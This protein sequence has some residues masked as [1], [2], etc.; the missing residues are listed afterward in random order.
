MAEFFIKNLSEIKIDEI[1]SAKSVALG[2]D[3]GE[4]TIGV[5]ISDRRIKIASGVT[6]I[7]RKRTDRDFE[8]LLES[9]KYHKIGVV[10]LGWPLQ[11]NGLA[12]EQC[13]K[14]LEFAV[15]LSKYI[16]ADFV[17]WDERF[18]TKV[19]NNLMIRA[20]LSRKKRKKIVDSSAAAYIL[21]G[22]IDFMNYSAAGDRVFKELE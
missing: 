9:V 18:S 5:A 15:Q 19:V 22:A 8:L 6:I 11:M 17:Q 3:V 4:K 13:G 1:I 7:A 14:I 2:L 20:D 10:I 12:G 21:Q 16:N